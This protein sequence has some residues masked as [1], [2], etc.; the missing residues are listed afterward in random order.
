MTVARSMARLAESP[1]LT[2][3]LR[4]AEL[5]AADAARSTDPHGDARRL[6]VALDGDDDVVSI[7]S[8]HALGSIADPLADE[9]LVEMLR[10]GVEPLAGHAAWV[11]AARRPDDRAIPLLADLALSGGFAGM[12]AERT[13]I[14]WARMAP[15][16]VIVPT[17]LGNRRP[18]TDRSHLRAGSVRRS[19]GLVI[20]Q[21][22]LHARL[23]ESGS[24]LG[25]GDAGGIA[26]LLR[27]LGTS[28]SKLENVNEVITITRG[29]PG[30]SAGTEAA[31]GHIADRHRL[32]RIPYG[33]GAT[34][35][36][37]EAWRYRS[38]LEH[39]M[40]AIG[41]ALGDRRVVWHLRMA[42]VGTLA[43]SAVAR[44]LGQPVVFTAAPDPHVVIDALEDDGRLDRATFGRADAEFQYWF[45][46]RMVERL[47]AQV[48]H[49][50]L[51][52]RTTLQRELIDLVGLDEDD[53]RRRSD[54][55]PEGVDVKSIDAAIGRFASPSFRSP[56]VAEVLDGLPSRRRSLPWIVTVGRM[57]SMKGLHRIVAAVAA[58]PD[59]AA[60]FNVVMVGGDLVAPSSDER[61]A[62]A[63]IDRAGGALSDG[64]VTVLGHRPPS[65]IC[66]LLVHAAETDS[67]YVCASDKEEFGLAIVEALAAG[68]VVVA[69]QR[70]GPR[71]YIDHGRNGVLCDT[72]SSEAVAAAIEHAD[73][74]RAD[75]HRRHSSRAHVRAE[76][77]VDAMAEQLAAIYATLAPASA[78]A[79]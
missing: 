25:A 17:V 68:L 13:L 33:V 38:H 45:R 79:A 24:S 58:R 11:L 76:M 63:E 46:A 3:A 35:P 26:S 48:E 53:L 75:R 59:L 7:A 2:I 64:V 49:L 60:R 14:E 29:A 22:F 27:S 61:R 5:L 28:L 69:P 23:D 32:E 16:A 44:R 62:L 8:L 51:L 78:H 55:V 73:V 47:S 10:R 20:V 66:D 30:E 52:P 36:W 4:D 9:V 15:R 54:V 31:S 39:E 70:G 37:R 40:T 56:L 41:R 65:D 50:A 77:S 19:D 34:V 21:P 43:A 71:T 18:A 1:R 67:I 6:R 57:N 72:S 42:D 74:L 12:L